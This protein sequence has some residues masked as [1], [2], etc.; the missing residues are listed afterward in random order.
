MACNLDVSVISITGDCINTS[1][2]GFTFTFSGDA[3]GFTLQWVSPYVTTIPLTVSPYDVTGLT[4]GTYTFY[5]FDSCTPTN[6]ATLPINVY[7]SSGTCADILSTTNTTCDNLNGSITILSQNNYSNVNFFLY[8]KNVGFISQQG[9]N[10]NIS[11]QTTFSLLPPGTYYAIVDDGG[12][13]TGKTESCI[14][15]SSTTLDFGFYVIN[16]TDCG[17]NTGAIYITGLT[18]TPPY[19]YLWS[20]GSTSQSITGLTEGTYSVTI[21]DASGCITANGVGVSKVP[22]LNITT[23]FTTPPSCFSGDGEVTAVLTGGT[24]PYYFSGSNGETIITFSTSYTFTGLSSGFFEVKVTDAGLCNNSVTTSLL[25]P[26]SFSVLSITTT[27]SNCNNNDGNITISLLGGNGE[28]TY[29]LTDPLGNTTNVVI[30]ATNYTFSNLSSGT[31][32]LSIGNNGSCTYTQSYTITNTSLFTLSTTATG[33]TCNNSNGSA[34]LTIT[35][36]GTPPFFYQIDGQS[37]TTSL[38][39]HTFCGLSSGNYD[40]SVTDSLYCKQY[41][42][43]IVP[44]SDSVFFNLAGVGPSPGLSDGYVS[45]FITSGEPP[46]SLD[47]SDNVSTGQTGSTITGLTAGTYS[48]TVTDNNGCVQSRDAT[49]YGI[50]LF[51][52]YELYNVCSSNL[53]FT[54][55]V[56]KRGI[57]QY[58]IDGYFDLTSGDTGCLLNQAI[59]SIEATLTGTTILESFYTGT[60][61]YD[62]PTDDE[63]Y[64]TLKYV[65]EQFNGITYVEVDPLNNGLI[66]NTICNP[67]IGLID[68]TLS[69]SLK[70]Y[71]EINCVTCT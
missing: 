31:Y 27:N 63:M 70:I 57:K 32:I 15:K 69:I 47:W 22:T 38:L 52:S 18:G 23:L 17:V 3:P 34:T 14:I 54:G 51:T 2:G 61:L 67:P 1:S 12:G 35:T 46:F 6:S 37:I 68:A 41:S 28:Y 7:I 48:L 29:S 24:P 49:I 8:E 30:P 16:N 44:S 9:L 26:N 59:F 20:N 13:C 64:D 25:T 71:Y 19:S 39:S 21:S 11:T 10:Q 53:D 36:G 56:S 4:A 58:L 62:Y 45:A 40:A 42:N 55:V 66:V 33:T 65:V 50:K 5:V 60:T 43:F